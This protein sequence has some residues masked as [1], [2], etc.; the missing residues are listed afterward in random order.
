MSGERLGIA[1]RILSGLLFAGMV[2]CVKAVGDAAPLGQIVFFRSAVALIPLVIFLRLRGEFPAGLRT[3]RPF[4]HIARCLLGG[5]AMFTS[6]A[7]LR[8]LPVA[9]ATMLGYLSPVMQVAL[10]AVLLREM[11]GPRRWL[12][13][14]LGL[15]GAAALTAPGLGGGEARALGVAL[16]LLTA[17]LTAGA[18]IQVRR[19]SV[20]GEGAGAIAFYF[21]LVSALLGLATLPLGWALPDAPTLA[22]LVGA[23]LFGGAA[24]IAM[25]LSFRHAEASVLAPFE[26]L[27]LIW[28]ALAGLAVFAETPSPAFALAAPLVVAGAV[29]ASGGALRRSRPA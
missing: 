21:A 26:Y 12:G 24:H 9:E 13:V 10:A 25:T 6:F 27:T 23:G 2:V 11:V 5:A 17:A 4:G 14:A 8:L 1:L 22:A 15:A 16:G 18:L 29:V 19:L 20:L 7:T 3:R 28:A